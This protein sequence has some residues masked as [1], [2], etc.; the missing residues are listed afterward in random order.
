MPIPAAPVRPKAVGLSEALVKPQPHPVTPALGSPPAFGAIRTLCLCHRRCGGQSPPPGLK[1]QSR[2]KWRRYPISGPPEV[3]EIT[4]NAPRSRSRSRPTVGE[5]DHDPRPTPSFILLGSGG[6]AGGLADLKLTRKS[7][8]SIERRIDPRVAPRTASALL[9]SPWFGEATRVP[10]APL[11]AA[12]FSSVRRGGEGP[13]GPP[14]I[15][16]GRQASCRRGGLRP[17]THSVR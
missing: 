15:S 12:R 11:C 17:D 7:L 8:I 10:W 2:Q 16:E 1:A 5:H 4:P 6:H 3:S 14:L 9:D 13:L